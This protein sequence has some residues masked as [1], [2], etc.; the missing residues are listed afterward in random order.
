MLILKNKRLQS[1]RV[2][3]NSYCSPTFA[4]LLFPFNLTDATVP[5][6]KDFPANGVAAATNKTMVVLVVKLLLQM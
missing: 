5:F 1:P 4:H 3:A 6:P 2:T